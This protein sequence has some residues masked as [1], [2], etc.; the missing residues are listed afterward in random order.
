MSRGTVA[1]SRDKD[2]VKDR[3]KACCIAVEAIYAWVILNFSPSL[4]VGGR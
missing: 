2:K 3:I 4:L 1:G